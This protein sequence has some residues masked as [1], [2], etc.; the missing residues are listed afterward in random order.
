MSHSLQHRASPW[1]NR[2]DDSHLK[3][4]ERDD[5]TEQTR[6]DRWC[7]FMSGKVNKGAGID[8][9]KAAELGD[10]EGKY[11]RLAIKEKES[12]G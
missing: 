3:H 9:N 2:R 4:N 5:F 6:H 12:D 8:K 7:E 10:P 1:N 11:H